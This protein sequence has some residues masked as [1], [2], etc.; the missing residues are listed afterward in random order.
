MV[1]AVVRRSGNGGTKSKSDEESQRLT[2][3]KSE[4]GEVPHVLPEGR[5]NDTYLGGFRVYQALAG[6]PSQEYCQAA[7]TV[8]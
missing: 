7:W 6:Q 5:G 8:R 1:M 2:G 3:I 4:T